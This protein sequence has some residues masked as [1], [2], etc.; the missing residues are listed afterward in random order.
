[1]LTLTSP[2]KTALHRVPAVVKVAVLAGAALL[3]LPLRD[4]LWVL[5]VLAL[6]AAMYLAQGRPFAR[7]GAAILRPLWPFVVVIVLWQAWR[8]DVLAGVAIAGKM[9]A[10]VGL[11][12][13]VTLTT[14]LT[15][16]IALVERG[17]AP[18]AR[19]GMW[20]KALSPA[21]LALS[22]ALAIRFTPVLMGKADMLGQAWRARARRR[23]GWRIVVP[24][25]LVALDDAEQVAEA[26]RARGGI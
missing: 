16:M 23:V 11:A 15:A 25:V 10:A 7:H 9:V 18:L 2:Y 21:I 12:N 20:P 22:M 24:L 1:M 5:G 13:L 4:P 17:V 3:V 14:P 19:F 6:V 8:G 26:L